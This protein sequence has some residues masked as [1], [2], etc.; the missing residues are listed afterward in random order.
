MA[1]TDASAEPVIM[2]LD[3]KSGRV[4]ESRKQGFWT[5]DNP[6]WRVMAEW[7]VDTSSSAALGG[8]VLEILARDLKSLQLPVYMYLQQHRRPKSACHAAFVDLARS[9]EE[10]PLFPASVLKDG[11]AAGL[12][13]L[14][15]AYIPALPAFVL[16]HLIEC[17]EFTPRP[18][19]HCAW[20][21]YQTLC[22]R[23]V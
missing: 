6:L 21:P 9:G 11:G 15:A 7:R 3:Y 14:Y 20:C 4:K 22:R 8:D 5:P 17:D 10:K 1:D 13:E 2:I 12:R 16:R 23:R 18:G 19:G